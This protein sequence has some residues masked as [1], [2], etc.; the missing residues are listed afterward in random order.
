MIAK[1]IIFDAERMKYKYNGLYY[2][3]YHLGHE[4]MKLDR[5]NE[6]HFY[7]N[8]KTSPEFGLKA[9]YIKQYSYEKFHMPTFKGYDVWHSSFQLSNYFPRNKKIKVVSTIHDLNFLREEQEPYIIKRFLKKIQS[10]ID[11]AD[12]IVAISNYVRKDI[13]ENCNLR[14]KEIQ[15]IYN[16]N[17]IDE[18]KIVTT[19]H[20]EKSVDNFIFTIGTINKKKNL[21]ILPYLLL[22]NKLKLIISGAINE[23]DYQKKILQIACEI[24]VQDRLTLTGPIT[25]EQKYRYLKECSLFV[26]PSIT[27]GFGL[28]VIE[29]MAFGKKVLLSK[30]TC[31]PEIGGDRAFYLDSDEEE[32]ME[33][34]GRNRIEELIDSQIDELSIINWAKNFTWEKSAKSYW[35]LYHRG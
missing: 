32:F 15:V 5:D 10:N 2:F 14:G 19:T 18:S 26:F 12:D 23:P 11:R 34:F 30:H 3:C 28:P 27:E 6:L 9:Q 24:G 16:G 13:I 31:L 7:Y 33:Y 8:N 22:G 1:N 25:E 21:H 35:D 20:Q 17:N 29:A 4:L